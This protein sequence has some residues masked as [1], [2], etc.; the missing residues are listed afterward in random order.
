MGLTPENLLLCLMRH[1]DAQAR[2]KRGRTGA[3]GQCRQ[4]PP[5][6]FLAHGE[7]GAERVRIDADTL[8]LAKQLLESLFLRHIPPR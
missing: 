8:E 4:R 6:I 1:D 7:P 2:E 5:H 3:V